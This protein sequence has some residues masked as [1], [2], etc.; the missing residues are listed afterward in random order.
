MFTPEDLI[1]DEREYPEQSRQLQQHYPRSRADQQSL[2]RIRTRFMER[3]SPLFSHGATVED[4]PAEKRLDE[5]TDLAE[6][7]T[8]VN[9]PAIPPIEPARELPVLDPATLRLHGL[10]QRQRSGAKRG[11]RWMQVLAAMLMVCV[12]VSGFVT[13]LII[14]R[15]TLPEP[16]GQPRSTGLTCTAGSWSDEID[17]QQP[18]ALTKVAAISPTDAWA[19]GITD[20]NAGLI[21]HWNGIRWTVSLIT[22]NAATFYA[23]AAVSANDVWVVGEQPN[24][25]GSPIT[26]TEHWDGQRWHVVPSLNI[27]GMNR[28]YAITALSANDIWAVGEARGYSYSSGS[29]TLIEHWDGTSWKL[30]PDQGTQFREGTLV[31]VTAFSPENVWAAGYAPTNGGAMP[32]GSLLEHW[33][34]QS[35][36]STTSSPGL[37]IVSVSAVSPTDVWAVGSVRNAQGQTAVEIA[38][39][40]GR[41]W[42]SAPR[43][44][45]NYDPFQTS[46]EQV[47]AVND[48]DVW[49]VGGPSNQ[50]QALIAHWDG[51]SW[52][53]YALPQP[54]NHSSFAVGLA[55][56]GKAVWV[57]GRRVSGNPNNPQL[58][59]PL[60]AQQFTCH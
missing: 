13:L 54:A 48:K 49:L 17:T 46:I 50:A 7:E 29:Q 51:N 8:R 34:G 31:T 58:V 11:T 23:V 26:I 24:H 16:S 9:I 14:R 55:V 57:V 36:Q 41:Q 19:V 33:D 37:S 15:T 35:W 59:Q 22:E 45:P 3:R 60:F 44:Q 6:W 53:M 12:L 56:S 28:L 40:N 38:R 43:L 20:R 18:G 1:Q 42:Q 47:V 27:D 52:Q 25:N 30:V 5:Q 2:L 10:D 21:E 39:W 4:I 32:A